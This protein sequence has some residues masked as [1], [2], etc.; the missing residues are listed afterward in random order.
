MLMVR[1]ARMSDLDALARMASAARPVLHS[2]PPD[3][4]ALAARI[5]LSE[6]AFCAP[7]VCP[8]A[9]FYLFVLEESATGALLGTA[10]IV[11]AAGHA[12]PF[13]VFRNNALI[14]ASSE[15]SVHR[16]IHALAMSHELTGQSRLVGFYIESSQ[17]SDA[18]AYLLSRARM[19]YIAAHRRRFT[20]EIFSL[21]LGVTDEDGASPFWD[22]VGRKFFG[23]EFAA[24]EIQSGGRSRTFIAEVMPSYPLYVPLLPEA[25]QQV[26]GVPNAQ[27]Q[28]AYAIHLDEGFEPGRYVDIFD[29]GPVL[30]AYVDRLACV[31]ENVPRRVRGAARQPGGALHLLATCS[32][33]AFRCVL[34]EVPAAPAAD[35]PLT[36]AALAALGVA[37]GERVC[38]VPLRQ[39][40]GVRPATFSG[41]SR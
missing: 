5:A 34:A 21:L 26:L 39:R 11:A 29:A 17:R 24:V 35:V 22:A 31:T 1:P 7:V 28:L 32:G 4:S 3:R 13:Y 10:G 30:T 19:M 25:A 20:P 41:D 14:H 8:G 15:L 2:L 36:A 23:R 33:E 27:A 37:E 40:E 18:A 12:E 6:A 9:E 16:K 38:C